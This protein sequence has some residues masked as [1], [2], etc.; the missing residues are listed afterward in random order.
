MKKSKIT[1]KSNFSANFSKLTF[2]LIL[3]YLN[4]IPKMPKIMKKVQHMRT[5]FP[6]GLK[7]ESSV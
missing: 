4:L 1:E 2:G 7:E 5:I 6:I 3:F